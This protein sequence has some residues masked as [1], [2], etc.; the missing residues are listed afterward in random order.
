MSGRV[1]REQRLEE[2]GPIDD[3]VL[4]GV[5]AARRQRDAD[6]ISVTLID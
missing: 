2:L 1:V 4:R 5:G 6:W 3:V